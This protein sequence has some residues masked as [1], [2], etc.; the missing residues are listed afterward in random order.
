MNTKYNLLAVLK[1]I[2]VDK[3]PR[4]FQ[5]YPVALHEAGK[6]IAGSW[7]ISLLAIGEVPED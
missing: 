6:Q 4:P 7:R 3:S 5:V 1:Y 2:M